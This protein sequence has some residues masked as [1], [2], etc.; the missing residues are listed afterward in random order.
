MSLVALAA[1]ISTCPAQA[2]SGAPGTAPPSPEVGGVDLSD[3]AARRQKLEGWTFEPASLD[4]LNFRFHLDRKDGS[5]FVQNPRYGIKLFSSWGRRGFASVRLAGGAW[6]PLDR[7]EALEVAA[8]KLRFRGASQDPSAPAVHFTFASLR[9]GAE[10]SLSFELSESSRAS[11]EH[12]RLLDEAL[13]TAD[14]DGD[15]SGVALGADLG[16]WYSADGDQDLDLTL[17]SAL[18]PAPEAAPGAPARTYSLPLAAV[19]RGEAGFLVF[20]DDPHI[21]VRLQ[22]RAPG[23]DFPGRRGLFL[24]L[25]FDASGAGA[26]RGEVSLVPM[27]RSEIGRFEP[28]HLYRELLGGA[29]GIPSLRTRTGKEPGQRAFLGAALFRPVLAASP[30]PPEAAGAVAYTFDDVARIGERLARDLG[31][32]EAL[33]LLD[34]WLGS[35]SDPASGPWTAAEEC[36]GTAGLKDCVRRLGEGGFLLG[37]VI[38]REQLLAPL[39]RGEEDRRWRSF[40]AAASG[41][42]GFAELKALYGAQLVVLRAPEAR[43]ALPPEELEARQQVFRLGAETFGLWG[44]RFGRVQDLESAC[45]LEGLLGEDARARVSPQFFP[46]F[47][48]AF[49][50]ASRSSLPLGR[51]LGPADAAGFLAHL[52]AGEAPVYELPARSH[53]DRRPEDPVPAPGDGP[54]WCFSRRDGWTAPGP[55]SAWE[56]FLKN[57]FEVASHVARIRAREPMTKHRHLRADGTVQ[58]GFFGSDMRVVVNFGP[59]DYRDAEEDFVLPAYGFWVRHPNF[60]AFHARRADGLDYDRPALFTVRSLEGKMIL[61]AEKSRIF[62]G[63]G[64]ARLRIGAREFEVE[65]E[66]ELRVW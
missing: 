25:E 37:L 53:F 50:H 5:F 18:A 29:L 4:G 54:E 40:L 24:T 14:G 31:I 49:G 66:A 19:F 63:F 48:I 56:V 41:D 44:T 34:G 65:R 2:T 42:D 30:S 6:L 32:D 15:G 35:G 55:W 58:E 13:W 11:V 1:L 28:A 21:V 7:I 52:I 9:Q 39:R 26:P 23:G 16:E 60:R 62:H 20:W 61:R 27:T 12:V 38:E 46:L 43:T 22:R 47:P 36:G 33:F 45:L 64:P 59:E 57:T 17:R 51:G 3:I 10:L 8:E